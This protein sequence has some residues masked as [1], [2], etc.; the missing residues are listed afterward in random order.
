MFLEV[1]T[2]LRK[3]RQFTREFKLWTLDKILT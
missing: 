2:M 1:T 3:R